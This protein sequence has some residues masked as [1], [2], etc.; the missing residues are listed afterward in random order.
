MRD[1]NCRERARDGG[2]RRARGRAES[3]GDRVGALRCPEL[4]L[5]TGGG[6]DAALC[7]SASACG[8]LVALSCPR[9][10]AR[11]APCDACDRL[12]TLGDGSRCCLF[13]GALRI[14]GDALRR[15]LGLEPTGEMDAASAMEVSIAATGD[16]QVCVR[17]KREEILRLERERAT[18]DGAPPTT[19]AR[20]R[21][22]STPTDDENG[23]PTDIDDRRLTLSSVQ[24]GQRVV[25]ESIFKTPKP[26]RLGLAMR[27]HSVT[28]P[29]GQE[30][31][32]KND[33]ADATIVR[34]KTQILF[35]E[36]GTRKR[37][38]AV[39]E[40]TWM[41]HD[42]LATA[43][44]R[45]RHDVS[46]AHKLLDLSSAF[47]DDVPRLRKN[48]TRARALRTALRTLERDV[49][50]LTSSDEANK[51]LTLGNPYDR[52]WPGETRA[53]GAGPGVDLL[54]RAL[55]ARSEWADVKAE[56]R[57]SLHSR[58]LREITRAQNDLLAVATDGASDF[59]TQAAA[60]RAIGT[61][62]SFYR[63]MHSLTCKLHQDY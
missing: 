58:R 56:E 2:G 25:P 47:L 13:C 37:R 51:A 5:T 45:A 49:R 62:I 27:A 19:V 53:Y 63:T 32:A 61:L 34:L 50:L 57:G 60:R 26:S 33:A 43:L 11:V 4:R 54:S 8:T 35:C 6:R 12:T 36:R 40:Y 16:E 41:E 52:V 9:C 42:I 44:R 15:E 24:C 3:V 14:E 23:T 18:R 48:L 31:R 20:H 28:S 59:D 30:E 10:R 55:R 7:E 22:S 17:A 29:I 39:A 21:S 46:S 38:A 1:E